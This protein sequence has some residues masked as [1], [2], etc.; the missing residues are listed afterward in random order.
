MRHKGRGRQA[1]QIK[2]SDSGPP[3]INPFDTAVQDFIGPYGAP[4]ANS[5]HPGGVNVC[6]AD[7]SVHFVKSSVSLQVWWGLGTRSGGE[8]IGS[9]AY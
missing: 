7:G 5:L 1:S 9:D 6:F 4:S 3:C 2:R 8:V